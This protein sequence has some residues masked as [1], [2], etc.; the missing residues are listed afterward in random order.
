MNKEKKT[1]DKKGEKGIKIV[2]IYCVLII[3]SIILFVLGIKAT[4]VFQSVLFSFAI[5]LITSLVII[6][7]VDLNLEKKAKKAEEKQ[8]RALEISQIKS[9]HSLIKPVL[10]IYT[11]EF[12]QLTTPIND[13][14]QNGEFLPINADTLNKDFK[15]KDLRDILSIDI[16][17]Y[18]RLGNTILETYEVIHQRMTDNF[19]NMLFLCKFKYYPEI[20]N[21]VSD[22]VNLANMPTSIDTLCTLKDNQGLKAV[23]NNMLDSYEGDPEKDL[24]EDKYS[25]NIFLC[26]ILIYNHLKKMQQALDKYCS[27]ISELITEAENEI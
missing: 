17:V 25:G 27:L 9:C 18:G 10:S 13:R 23:L 4:G 21:A 7:F 24:A 5:N 8:A 3:V 11:L 26:Y 22:I 14:T 19:A 1:K 20:A 2:N 16:T 6:F 15:L 12:N